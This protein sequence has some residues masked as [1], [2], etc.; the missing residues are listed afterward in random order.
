MEWQ[1]PEISVRNGEILDVQENCSFG[2]K[3]WILDSWLW[4][5]LRRWSTGRGNLRFSW[6]ERD[7][8]ARKPQTEIGALGWEG[9]GRV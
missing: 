1:T 9:L 5:N 7:S 6:R 3:N 8:E 4:A 2:R